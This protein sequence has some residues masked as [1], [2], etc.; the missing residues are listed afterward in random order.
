M[1]QL[2]GA[3]AWGFEKKFGIAL[4]EGALT[5]E[6]EKCGRGTCPGA[7]RRRH[8]DSLQITARLL[9]LYRHQ[10]GLVQSSYFNMADFGSSSVTGSGIGRLK[11]LFQFILKKTHV[12]V[13]HRRDVT[14]KPTFV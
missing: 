8:M 12:E 4:E 13:D 5:P 1:K 9:I 2:K 11:S 3:L 7:L 6:E 14:Q 10:V